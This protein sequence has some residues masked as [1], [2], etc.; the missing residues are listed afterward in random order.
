MSLSF[1]KSK[2]KSQ[3]NKTNSQDLFIYPDYLL[4][5]FY[6]CLVFVSQ[7]RSLI[8][9]VNLDHSIAPRTKMSLILLCP[10]RSPPPD[11]S[12]DDPLGR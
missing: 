9:Y 8:V 1:Y 4:E 3:S 7:E 6:C 10:R 12:R 5:L 2:K 11:N